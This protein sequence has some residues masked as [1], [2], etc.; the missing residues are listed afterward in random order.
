MQNRV[1]YAASGIATVG[2]SIAL[3]CAV[4]M[5]NSAVLANSAG[6]VVGVDPIVLS[7]TERAS[8]VPMLSSASSVQT[9]ADAQIPTKAAEIVPADEAT[10]VVPA[11]EPASV[12]SSPAAAAATAATTTTTTTTAAAA[13]EIARPAKTAPTDSSESK[14]FEKKAHADEKKAQPG[15]KKSKRDETRSR[16]SDTRVSSPQDQ[17]ASADRRDAERS[18]KTDRDARQ[19]RSHDSPDRRDR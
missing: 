6:A 1:T 8:G 11:D 13:D 17:S 15:E 16:D 12:L 7:V 19:T 10:V 2:A 3:V 4:T 18:H 14:R 9:P 5:T